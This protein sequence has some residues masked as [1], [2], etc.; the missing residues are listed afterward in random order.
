MSERTR[1]VSTA[2]SDGVA[3]APRRRPPSAPEAEHLLYLIRSHTGSL[4]DALDARLQ[5]DGAPMTEARYTA[6]LRATSAIAVPL[7]VPLAI[8]LGP[9]V[10]RERAGERRTRLAHDLELLGSSLAE[11]WPALPV[12]E[13][14]GDAFGAAYV[15]LGSHLGGE[16]IA[17]RLYGRDAG[18]AT[19]AS[20][21]RLY[22]QD[23]G[24]AWTRFTNALAA[25][26]DAHD[27]TV[28]RHV[29]AVA[30]AL[31]TA[32]GLALDREGVP[33]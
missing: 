16:V 14:A 27:P 32:F 31:F 2:L 21:A 19:P 15:L 9:L 3:P 4:H 18:P 12:I 11:P 24:P 8:H 23:L 26:G 22:G 5:P 6:F 30:V 25:F 29:A 7:E 17:R 28:R 1:E 10:V 20:Y 33:R 13:S